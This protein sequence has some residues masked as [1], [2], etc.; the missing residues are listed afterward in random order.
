MGPRGNIW[1]ECNLAAVWGQM[2]TDGGHSRLQ[3]TMSILGVP[4]MSPKSFIN[5][6]WDTSKWWQHELQQLMDEVGKKEKWLAPG[7][8]YCYT[9]YTG[10]HTS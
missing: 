8:Q 2:S 9:Y 10:W 5:T 6:E 1:W 4:A 3:E 7:L